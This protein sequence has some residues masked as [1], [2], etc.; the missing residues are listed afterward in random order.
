MTTRDF[1]SIRGG[2]FS[3][4]AGCEL[5]EPGFCSPFLQNVQTFSG[6]HQAS[7]SKDTG[8]LFPSL[9]VKLRGIRVTIHFY[10]TTRLRISKAIPLLIIWFYGIYRENL[11]IIRKKDVV[12]LVKAR[13]ISWIG[14]VE[15]MEDKK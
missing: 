7:Y 14:H 2:V 12:K 15:R 11:N 13:R 8:G 5:D 9:G 3:L 10:L 6:S 4:A 1:H